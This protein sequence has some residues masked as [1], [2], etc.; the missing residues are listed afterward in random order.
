MFILC[1]C[2]PTYIWQCSIYIYIYIY[3]FSLVTLDFVTIFWSAFSFCYSH[4]VWVVSPPPLSRTETSAAVQLKGKPGKQWHRILNA[5]PSHCTVCR[6]TH[7]HPAV[8]HSSMCTQ[9]FPHSLCLQRPIHA[10]WGWHIKLTKAPCPQK[11]LQK[12]H[13]V[14]ANPPDK[15]H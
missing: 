8:S 15:C 11:T 2:I 14:P 4:E 5:V 9:P 3:I 10:S 7:T 12:A 6:N 1:L 13:Y